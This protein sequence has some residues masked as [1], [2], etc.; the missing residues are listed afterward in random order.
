MT[1][2]TNTV[3]VKSAM[4]KTDL[5]TGE[6]ICLWKAPEVRGYQKEDDV[7]ASIVSA[8]V[9]N[10][11]ALVFVGTDSHTMGRFYQYITVLGVY[12]PGKGGTYF[13]TFDVEER[14]NYKGAQKVRMYSEATKSI[15]VAERI[16]VA[17]GIVPEVHLDVSPSD[18]KEFTSQLA[19]QLSGYV[20]SSG[21]TVKTKPDSWA[22]SA[23]A[24]RHAR[25]KDRK[26]IEQNLTR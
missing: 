23:I 15:E 14:N 16:K 2:R 22:A 18:K 25:R 3:P 10:P 7:F 19:E 9:Q 4:T 20:V 1:K 5:E 26:W 13:F 12:V 17:T 21:F 24:D 8:R 6:K 11:N